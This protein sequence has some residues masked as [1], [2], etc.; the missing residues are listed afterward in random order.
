MSTTKKGAKQTPK[1]ATRKMVT[2]TNGIEYFENKAG[3]VIEGFFVENLTKTG[4]FGEQAYAVIERES[5][6]KQIGMPSNKVLND[7]FSDC[8][9][10]RFVRVTY[11]GKKLKAGEKKLN[12][13]GNNAYHDYLIEAEEE[14]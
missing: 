4:K 8:K 6:S 3:N 14:N 9:P 13:K 2:V 11:K 1:K 10:G 7:F 12:A 5:D